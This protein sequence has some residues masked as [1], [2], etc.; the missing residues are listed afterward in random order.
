MPFRWHERVREIVTTEGLGDIILSGNVPDASWH[1]FASKLNDGDPTI[2]TVEARATG[3]FETFWATFRDG[4]DRLE[5]GATIEST[6]DDDPVDFGAGNKNVF[7]GLPA[8]LAI[9]AL[10]AAGVLTQAGV[11]PADQL[12]EAQARANIG[13]QRST[14]SPAIAGQTTVEG[15]LAAIGG[16]ELIDQINLSGQSSVAFTDLGDYAEILVVSI[17]VASTADGIR[18]MRVSSDNGATWNSSAVYL[19]WG[20]NEQATTGTSVLA[21]GTAASS[22]ARMGIYHFMNWNKPI[23]SPVVLTGPSTVIGS[24]IAVS[25][26]FNALQFSDNA[27]AMSGILQIYGRR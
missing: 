15:A 22:T 19:R 2:V 3:A 23:Y 12:S 14:I 17:D 26:A 25:T 6:N 1:T 7:M 10:L 8:R 5:R 11:D 20:F 18:F 9:R 13:A 21:T 24:L 27:G 16:W 4:P